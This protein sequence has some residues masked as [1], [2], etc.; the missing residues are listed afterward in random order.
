MT[1]SKI[2]LAAALTLLCAVPVAA[3][4]WDQWRGAARDGKVT[5]FKAPAAWPAQLTRKWKIEVGEGHASP[6]VVGN[7]AFVFARQGE[8]EVARSVELDTGREVWSKSYPVPYEM[9][10]A[11]RGHGKGPKSTPLH[12]KGRLYTLGIT[13]VLTC[14]EAS[15]GKVLWRKE[16]AGQHKVTAPDFG[17]AVSPLP[18]G[19]NLIV[20]TG[21]KD[22]GALTAFDARTG[23]VKWK[24]T[25]DGP[26]YASPLPVTIGGVKQL[27]T[28]TQKSVVGVEASTGRLLW[29]APFTT[30][31]D[32]NSISPVLMGDAVL[33]GGVGKPTFALR[34]KKDGGSWSTEKVWETTDV[35]LYMSTPVLTGGK[36]VGMSSKR[37]GQMFVMDPASGKVT[38]SSEGRMGD[39]I[40]VLDAGSVIF[41]QTTGADLIV[42][43]RDGDAL[44]EVK[45]YSVAD[46]A[47]WATPAVVGNRLLVKDL[48]SLALWEIGK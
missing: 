1:A 21:G 34:I 20:H 14:W 26:G 2:S 33:V 3:D 38:W 12:A 45:K 31:Y 4:D 29:S 13:G 32:Q 44:T 8:N 37:M 47:T 40:A 7:R 16:F 39:N 6:L 30:P 10:P 35:S 22:D 28:Q 5:G 17:T 42:Y 24:W 46:S 23:E 19:D 15:T 18:D 36:L 43:R 9:N 11:A 41:A 25:G 27:V 48:N